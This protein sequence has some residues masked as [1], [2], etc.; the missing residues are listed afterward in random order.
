MSSLLRDLALQSFL[1]AGNELRLGWWCQ[2]DCLRSCFDCSARERPANRSQSG[3]Q[4]SA[5]EITTVQPK[6][7]WWRHIIH[8]DNSPWSYTGPLCRWQDSQVPWQWWIG[9][10]VTNQNSQRSIKAADV[11]RGAPQ[12]ARIRIRYVLLL[13][14]FNLDHWGFQ[15]RS[16]GC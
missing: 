2:V 6:S 4:E 3:L 7:A 13:L 9:P 12:T 8:P 5:I 1:S 10:R 15:I 11:E 16:Q 14:P